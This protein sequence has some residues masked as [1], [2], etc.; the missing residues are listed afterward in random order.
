MRGTHQISDKENLNDEE[1]WERMLHKDDEAVSLLYQR[2]FDFL[3][4]YG[5]HGMHFKIISLL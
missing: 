1:L 2:Y 5:L 4:N 3:Y